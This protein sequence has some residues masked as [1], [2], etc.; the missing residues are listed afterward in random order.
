MEAS[1]LKEHRY[2]DIE[3]DPYYFNHFINMGRHNAYL[4]IH[5]IYESV[6]KE[7]LN[8]EE[9]SLAVF[10]KK[11]IDRS[12][13]KPDEMTKVISL[14]IRH[15]PFLAYYEDEKR[16]KS[17][18]EK[19]QKGKEYESLNKLA[20]YLETLNKIRNQTSHYKHNK[21]DVSL[22]K[23]QLLFEKGIKEAQNRMGY[24]DKDVKHLYTNAY[25][26]LANNTILTEAGIS[27]FVCLFLD[28]KNGYL[29][30]SR[31][32][33]FKDK[34]KTSE[35]YKSAT[36][37][38]FTQFHC[39]VP[40][41]KLE[42]SDIALD[43]LNELNRCPK[44]LYN[45]L[46]NEDQKKFIAAISEKNESDDELPE[47]IMKRSEDRFP[48][49]ALRYFE[50]S[51]TLDGITFQLY[52]GR[53]Q[54]QE[55][56]TKKIAGTERAHLLLKNMHLFGYLPFYQKKE[57]HKFYKGNEEVEFYAPAFRMAGN[58]IGLVLRDEAQEQYAVP[59]TNKTEED[60]NYPDAIL[61]THELSGLFFYN[62]LHE[63][64]W[65]K[66]SPQK[67][68]QNYLSEFRRFI[69]DLQKEKIHP[70]STAS[71]VVGKRR[72]HKDED[73][74]ILKE[75]SSKLQTLLDGYGLK[76]DWIPDACREYLLNYK[77]S[78]DKFIIKDKFVTMKK[79]AERKLTR[80]RAFAEAERKGMVTM[81]VTRKQLRI[82]ELAQE[83]A[84]DIVFL[85]PPQE[86]AT[87][88]KKKINNMEFDVLQ[89]M[90]AYFPIYKDKLKKY[91]N[92]LKEKDNQWKHPFLHWVFTNRYTAYSSLTDVY[93]AY[94]Q[95]KAKWIEQEI[96]VETKGQRKFQIIWKLKDQDATAA[97]YEYILKLNQKTKLA[98]EKVYSDKAVYLP[99]DLF[100]ACIVKAMQQQGYDLKEESNV[101]G[102]LMIYLK[103]KKQ[104]MYELP[105]YYE[106]KD[107]GYT[108]Q[109]PRDELK[110]H[111]KDNFKKVSEETAKIMK[112]VAKRIKE[113]EADIL[114]QQTN[115]RAL[116]LMV[117]DLLP[118]SFK[119][120]DIERL[121][122]DQQ[123]NILESEYD[124]NECIY[125]RKVTARLPIKRYGEFRRFLKDRRLESLIKYYPEGEDIP[126][127]IIE[128]GKVQQKDD[129]FKYSNLA[130]EL[131]LYEMERDKLLE[132]MYNVEK[133]LVDN[134]PEQI[135]KK[136]NKYY[137][138][139][140]CLEF[141]KKDLGLAEDVDLL[142]E[143]NFKNLRN[144]MLH[145]QIPYE[146]W[147]KERTDKMEDE[148]MITKRIIT[149]IKIVYERLLNGIELKISRK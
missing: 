134:Y 20:G 46:G 88:D 140:D 19:P 60:K 145:N 4:I 83:L 35:R 25:Y 111:I 89:K 121:G 74:S 36:L 6:Y 137:E 65:I 106:A 79:D 138:H 56:H 91:L 102:C 68:I 63:K 87:G 23:Y 90:L 72:Q 125:G 71:F 16:L 70:V 80:I 52:L 136:D 98:T 57:A 126:L 66:D 45:V 11:V 30:L 38:A 59:L 47:P 24:E 26:K 39:H 31:I 48:Y 107:L 78:S 148:P 110:K 149:L 40:Y 82:G 61:S 113:N 95:S 135:T 14:L 130:E 77:A 93:E 8:V 115:D 92:V 58:R 62:F 49:F 84:R 141:A 146:S 15:F 33:G 76:M 109:E 119:E 18:E 41:P 9:N 21:E 128:S 132:L 94:Y 105:R 12:Q 142:N 129:K 114:R 99:T 101:A 133:M 3:N 28:K 116:F 67:F 2:R 55:S 144:S 81:N 54:A 104:P 73:L 120:D 29:F 44:Q 51:D 124:M 85:T 118:A 139:Y 75:N 97:K 123:D 100:K 112:K 108:H 69:D 34:N 5:D 7:E 127:G 13:D 42:S 10:C 103:N 17:T 27:Y 50:E 147:I 64:G 131:E 32:K 86:T 43:M 1:D 117:N 53:K 96:L 122:F 37:E 143:E 22:P